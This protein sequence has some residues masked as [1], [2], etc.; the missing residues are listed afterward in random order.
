MY[1]LNRFSKNSTL[2]LISD[3]CIIIFSFF[4]SLLIKSDFS[5]SDVLPFL[6]SLTFFLL[7]IIK[8]FWL[9]VFASYI[10]MY[11]YTSIVDL[12]KLLKS[13]LLSSLSVYALFSL[14]LHIDN[15]E[16]LSIVTIDNFLCTVLISS[17]RLS[18][19]IYFSS[20]KSFG[21][22]GDSPLKKRNVIIIGAGYSG[23]NIAKQ[24]LSGIKNNLNVIG[25]L[26]DDKA[27]IGRYLHG[28][29]VLGS[30][31]LLKQNKINFDEILICIPSATSSEMKKIIDCCKY[32][33]KKFKTLP[34]LSELVE[35]Q[36]SLSQFR[37]VSFTD[38]L[39]REEI[40]LNKSSLLDFIRGK[41]IL[42]TGAGGSIG[43][44][45]VRQCIKFEPSLIIMVDFSELNLFEIEREFVSNNSN[46]LLKP[47]LSDI[48]ELRTVES[49]FEE[50]K[51][52]LVFHAAAYKH[53]PMQENFPWEAVKTNVFGTMNLSEMS[54]KYD[55][56]KFVL[57]STDKAVKPTNVMGATK[58][59]A[60]IMIQISNN[61][62]KHTEFM[63]V[64]FGNVLGSSGSVIPIFKEQ[65]K[66]GG[67]VTVTDP[68]ME[69]YFMSITEAGQLILQAGSLGNGGEIFIL[70]MGETVKIIDLATD[71]IKLSGF[72]P[73][74]IPIEITGSRPG[75]KKIEE[76]SLPNE[77]LD[78]TKHEKIFVLN[79]KAKDN[80]KTIILNEVKKMREKL[81]NF[82][83]N[84]LKTIL[85]SILSDY[86]PKVESISYDESFTISD[87]KVKA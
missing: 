60:E 29:K 52:Q 87:N 35:G 71:L 78:K 4:I 62:Q 56:E 24:L 79:N 5:L 10:G 50:Y 54:I 32:S 58:R 66:K 81:N 41:R 9:K 27:K 20:H 23:Q 36:I 43:S 70:D 69:R 31:S 61:D 3:V 59:L 16:L 73:S 1:K 17:L 67:P 25:F 8:V 86:I 77:K 53:V 2:L 34:S 14:L 76:L 12:V 7:V 57:V 83:S 84:E 47:V 13:S 39:R 42:V 85:S 18:I 45:L 28:I 30:I 48:I 63:A 74:Q 44:E 21:I 75:E 64:R 68:D 11:R 65:I 40:N 55:V 15:L 37:D 6:N 72:E 26:D 46:V 19:R 82:N 22:L 38:L 33:G 51:P 80:E 49:I